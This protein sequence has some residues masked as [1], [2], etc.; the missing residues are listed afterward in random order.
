MNE[1]TFARLVADLE[2]EDFAAAEAAAN[3]LASLRDENVRPLMMNALKN[4]SPLVQRVMLWALQNYDFPDYTPYLPYLTAENAD[5]KEAAQVLFMTEK[6]AATAALE[7]A[8]HSPDVRLQYAAVETLGHLRTPAAEQLLITA[9]EA[10][11]A[12]VRSLAASALSPFL[13]EKTI[14]ALTAHLTDDDEVRLSALFSLRKR[15]LSTEELNAVQPLVSDKNPEI[16]AAA[17]YVLDAAA[18]ESA[19][20]DEDFRVRRATAQGA[21]SASVLELLCKDPEASVRTAA[22]DAAAKQKLVFTKTFIGMLSDENPGVR[23]AAAA[24]L[25]NAGDEDKET[26]VAA[27]TAALRDKKP[28]VRAA[29]ANALAE[30]GGEAAKHALE[31][32]AA[33]KNPILAGIMKNALDNLKKKEE[34]NP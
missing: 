5:V 31:E 18:P 14:E 13:S 24:A 12:D 6:P 32:A 26:A 28:G 15:F 33:E 21:A 23:R 22:A 8:V 11:D 1:R 2:A 25:G 34:K 17:V 19:A 20:E 29:C 9:L 16:R 3:T 30:I 4:G 27:L 7:A 10:K